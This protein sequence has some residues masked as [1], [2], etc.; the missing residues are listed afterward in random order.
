MHLEHRLL[1]AL[2]SLNLFGTLQCIY[3]HNSAV[4][5]LHEVTLA[6]H[7]TIA[8]HVSIA[9]EGKA[10]DFES[11]DGIILIIVLGSRTETFL[12]TT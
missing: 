4:K 2:Y 8:T 6:T 10:A 12:I 7:A 3:G 11:S 9:S 5:H 1:L